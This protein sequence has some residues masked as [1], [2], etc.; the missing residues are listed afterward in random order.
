MKHRRNRHVNITAEIDR[1]I[2]GA[3]THDQARCATRSGGTNKK[4]LSDCRGAGGVKRRRNRIFVEIGKLEPGFRLHQRVVTVVA[5][6]R[7][8]GRGIVCEKNQFDRSFD[9]IPNLFDQG[10]KVGMYR[11]T[12]S[13]A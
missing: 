4:P 3:E 6:R 13:S 5:A 10:Q 2:E 11:M 12:S 1:G 8:R 9:A 7:D